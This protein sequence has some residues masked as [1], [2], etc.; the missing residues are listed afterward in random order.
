[1]TDSLQA[2]RDALARTDS[3]REKQVFQRAQTVILNADP[4]PR[5]RKEGLNERVA[6]VLHRNAAGQFMKKTKD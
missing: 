4:V 2:F 1:M 3:P 6:A 5:R